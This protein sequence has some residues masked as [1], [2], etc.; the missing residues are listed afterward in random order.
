MCP[1]TCS[2]CTDT[3]RYNLVAMTTKPTARKTKKPKST[4]AQ[5]RA[6][7]PIA[8]VPMT[9][10]RLASLVGI[11][12]PTLRAYEKGW[13]TIPEAVAKR[14]ENFCGASANWIMHGGTPRYWDGE[15]LTKA[16]VSAHR[17]GLLAKEF[18][19]EVNEIPLSLATKTSGILRTILTIT[20][21]IAD[22]HNAPEIVSIG[23]DRVTVAYP[24]YSPK[25]RD[26]KRR[27]GQA[28]AG[29]FLDSILVAIEPVLNGYVQPL[30]GMS[31]FM[32][33]QS[34]S[35]DPLDVWGMLAPE[36]T[37]VEEFHPS[38]GDP[39][40]VPVSPDYPRIAKSNFAQPAK[41]KAKAERVITKRK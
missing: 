30:G 4:I 23:E 27:T 38:G 22:R 8:G 29:S 25:I 12:Y 34:L 14:I 20:A 32:R 21:S 40:S 13:R 1:L 9:Q 28:V 35:R 15:E 2:D 24:E 5:L 41:L 26:M 33:A 6:L 7:M 11:K 10:A 17:A 3:F 16:K 31:D 37:R 36:A 39:D 19:A 18:W